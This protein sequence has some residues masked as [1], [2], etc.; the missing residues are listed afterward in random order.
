MINHT[1][2]S[3]GIQITKYKEKYGQIEIIKKILHKCKV[4]GNHILMDSDILG[5]HI[6]GTHR[7][8]EKV[9]KGNTV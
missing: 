3:H 1:L 7:I 9:Y 8:K 6:K 4:C 5:G 2:Q